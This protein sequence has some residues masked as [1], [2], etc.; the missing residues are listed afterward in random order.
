MSEE[1][2]RTGAEEL[3]P[4][5]IEKIYLTYQQ[6]IHKSE[7]LVYDI[8]R[9]AKGDVPEHDLL[10]MAVEAIGCLTDN[11]V[12]LPLVKQALEARSAGASP[13]GAEQGNGEGGQP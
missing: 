4:F 2:G 11:T 5:G 3:N 1:T 13:E 12:F 8:T 9:G 10:L 7:E 6:N